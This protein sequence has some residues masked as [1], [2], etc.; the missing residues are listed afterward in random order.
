MMRMII[1]IILMLCITTPTN[2]LA[3]TNSCNRASK[4]IVKHNTKCYKKMFK[5]KKPPFWSKIKLPK[6][7]KTKKEQPKLIEKEEPEEEVAV[8]MP[9]LQV[10]KIKM[11][12]LRKAS[13][14]DCPH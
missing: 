9:R 4:H 12:R 7:S 5:E 14:L 3:Q 13:A 2:S 6:R 10:P 1:V 11:P 8:E